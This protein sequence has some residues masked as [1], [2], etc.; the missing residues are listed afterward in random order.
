[1]RGGEGVIAN[2]EGLVAVVRGQKG[3]WLP[4]GGA[5]PGETSEE[6]VVREVREE[7]GRNIRLLSRIGEAVQFFYPAHDRCW[8]EMMAVFFRAEFE[9]EPVGAGEYELHWLDPDG[10]S[11]HFFH[12]CHAWA[13]AQSTQ[14][15]TP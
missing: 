10:H 7:L 14:I 12:T 15:T 4:G 5:D 11:D 6:T 13:V 2:S 8:Y 1:G 3:Y 9:G